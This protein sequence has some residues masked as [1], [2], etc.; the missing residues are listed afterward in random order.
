MDTHAAALLL[1]VGKHLNANVY[2]R[3]TNGGLVVLSQTDVPQTLGTEMNNGTEKARGS[4]TGAWSGPAGRQRTS[5]G[6]RPAG[7]AAPVVGADPKAQIE[8][9]LGGLQEHYPGTQHWRQDDGIWLLIP[10]RLISGLDHYAILVLA[11]QYET[12]LVRSWGFWASNTMTPSWIGPRHTNADGSICAFD[13]SDGTWTWTIPLVTLLDLYTIWVVRQLYVQVFGQWPGKQA[14]HFAGEMM[15]EFSPDEYC[16]CSDGAIRY[17]ECCMDKHLARNRIRDSL[18]FY[19][20]FGPRTPPGEVVAFV[21]R[22]HTPP[23]IKTIFQS[24]GE[25]AESLWRNE[26]SLIAL[27]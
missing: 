14:V 27:R 24:A 21:C 6:P 12:G 16:G 7:A 15:L 4:A 22:Q 1:E 18:S 26:A 5:G 13:M 10:T 8:D 3:V 9:Q 2:P 25:W 20:L 23:P 11:V 17:S 19:W